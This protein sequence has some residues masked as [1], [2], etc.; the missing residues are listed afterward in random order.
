[1]KM[2]AVIVVAAQQLERLTNLA[3]VPQSSVQ[4]TDGSIE[5]PHRL[6]SKVT[7]HVDVGDL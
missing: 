5:V 4:D 3:R 7:E 1:M 6:S 2:P